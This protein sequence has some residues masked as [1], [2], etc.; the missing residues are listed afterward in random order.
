M[1][2][3]YDPEKVGGRQMGPTFGTDFTDCP[4]TALTYANTRRGVVLVVDVSADERR[5]TREDWLCSDA[6][7]YMVW[8]H[9][10]DLIK[11]EVPAKELRSRLRVKGIWGAG[12]EDKSM[13][14][15]HALEGIVAGKP[16]L[17]AAQAF[18]RV[19]S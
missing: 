3:P 18:L 4:Y 6:K 19:G 2:H 9:F 14:L 12:P 11:A 5:L 1:K 7:R 13:V 8:G 16:G 15:R 10:D 17:A